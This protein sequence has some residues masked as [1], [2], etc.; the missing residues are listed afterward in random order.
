MVEPLVLASTSKW[1]AAMLK[2]LGLSF[3]QLA[4]DFDEL[5]VTGVT[6]ASAYCCCSDL[7]E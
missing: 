4:P 1:R 2:R 5:S 6:P 3:T 7:L